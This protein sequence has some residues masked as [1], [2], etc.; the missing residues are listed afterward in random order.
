MTEKDKKMIT[1]L[2][3]TVP[4]FLWVGF[5]IKIMWVWFM[6]PLGL[7]AISLAHAIGID[8][9]ITFIVIPSVNEDRSMSD[10]ISSFIFRPV[11]VLLIGF[12]AKSFM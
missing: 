9:L 1:I 2:L 6:V 5:V 11:F 4:A 7:P 10:I 8:V 12:I 3:I